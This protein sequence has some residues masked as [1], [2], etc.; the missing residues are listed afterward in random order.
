MST[1]FTAHTDILLKILLSCKYYLYC[2]Y[3]IRIIVFISFDYCRYIVG[4]GASVLFGTFMGPLADRFGR[5]RLCLVFCGVY[6]L[7]CL[8]K[9]SPNFWWLFVGR[10]FGS[11]SNAKFYINYSKIHSIPFF[12]GGISTSILFSTFE[13]WYVC[14]HSV[15]DFPPD[16]ISTTFSISTLWNGILAILSGIVADLGADWL[17]FGPVNITN[18]K[19]FI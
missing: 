3:I 4:F 11:F 18:S 2:N 10:F 17:D 6:S 9:I 19:T 13:A 8:T 14:Q 12:P 16:W 1:G 5:K 15:Q 7:C